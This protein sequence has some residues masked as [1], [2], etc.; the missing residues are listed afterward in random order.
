MP[1]LARGPVE[2][3]LDQIPGQHV[4]FHGLGLV[5]YSLLVCRI[6]NAV[7]VRSLEW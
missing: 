5:I 4:E 7:T 3:V 1:D 2:N 6:L